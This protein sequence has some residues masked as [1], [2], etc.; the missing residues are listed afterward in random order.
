[1]KKNTYRIPALYLPALVN[2]DT[3]G[4]SEEEVLKLN[5]WLEREQPGLATCPEGG[6]F[7][8]HGH[9]LNRNE[10]AECYEVVF[11]ISPSGEQ[12]NE[13]PRFAHKISFLPMMAQP[14]N[15]IE[16]NP[17]IAID[18][19]YERC[20]PD[21]PNIAMWCIYVHLVAGHVM[22]V[23][24]CDSEKAANSLY[25]LLNQVIRCVDQSEAIQLMKP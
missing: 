9:D 5:D 24:D 25:D 15:A 16:I 20:E 12:I 2:D 11:I 3:S 7:F 21:D 18:G 1:M 10:G 13:P 17:V 14:I 23:A 6:P 8:A 19:G 4:L 22:C